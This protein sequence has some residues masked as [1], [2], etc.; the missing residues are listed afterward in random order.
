MN[1]ADVALVVVRRFPRDNPL[2]LLVVVLADA[3]GPT[4]GLEDRA[5]AP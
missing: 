5:A 4:T 2:P 1:P 3:A